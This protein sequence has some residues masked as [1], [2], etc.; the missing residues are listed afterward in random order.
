[1]L[2]HDRSQLPWKHGY[3]EHGNQE[4]RVLLQVVQAFYLHIYILC[5]LLIQ[6]SHFD[7][8][9]LPNILCEIAL[10][11]PLYHYDKHTHENYK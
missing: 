7:V 9:V 4:V 8:L 6:V 5:I 3:N 11:S 2:Q 10:T 1:M